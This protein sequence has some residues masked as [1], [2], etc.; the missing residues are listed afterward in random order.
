MMPEKAEIPVQT[1]VASPT[2]QT[3]QG[4]SNRALELD[5]LVASTSNVSDAD[6]GKFNFP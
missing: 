6:I 2:E 1:P 4:F 5:M 3:H